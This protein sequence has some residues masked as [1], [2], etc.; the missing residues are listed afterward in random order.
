[1]LAG[2]T[3][4]LSSMARRKDQV[5]FKVR[6]KVVNRVDLPGVPAGTLGRV[7]MVNGLSWI[8]YRVVFDNGADVAF[9]EAEQLVTPEQWRAIQAHEARRRQLAAAGAGSS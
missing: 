2:R 6:Q 7:V 9:V 8:R 3:P 4:T 1:M 5:R